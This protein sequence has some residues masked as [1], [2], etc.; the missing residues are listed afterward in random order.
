M[1]TT[2]IY[3]ISPPVYTDIKY[4]L[5]PDESVDKFEIANVRSDFDTGSIRIADDFID[6]ILDSTTVDILSELKEFLNGSG[7]SLSTGVSLLI[8]CDE[9]DG[10]L[11]R[12]GDCIV[13]SYVEPE[14]GLKIEL[15]LD[16]GLI[17]ALIRIIDTQRF[18]L[19]CDS[20]RRLDDFCERQKDTDSQIRELMGPGETTVT[21]PV[22]ECD[23]KFELLKKHKKYTVY[24]CVKCG[25]TRKEF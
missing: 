12:N 7:D 21:E 17:N 1:Q 20:Y 15:E 9:M 5:G 13:A 19:L 3:T 24:K 6:L 18:L 11:V 2:V 8:D 22:P 23:H 14:P 25:E 4:R 10:E 16:S